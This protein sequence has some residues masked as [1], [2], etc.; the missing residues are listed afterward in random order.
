METE[1]ESEKTCFSK[2]HVVAISIGECFVLLNFELYSSLS[3]TGST[4]VGCVLASTTTAVVFVVVG[5]CRRHK[6]S[7]KSVIRK[8]S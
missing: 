2:T 7:I 4:L 1:D 6:T 5:L 8:G 3:L